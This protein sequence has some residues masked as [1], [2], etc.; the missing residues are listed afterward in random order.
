MVELLAEMDSRF[1]LCTMELERDGYTY[2]I[3]TLRAMRRQLA[4]GTELFYIIGTDTLFGA[5][6]LEGI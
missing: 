4:P 1:R 6:H 2:T 5:P 3:D